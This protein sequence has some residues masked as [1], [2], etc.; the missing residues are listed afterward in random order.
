[1]L[2]YPG[3]GVAILPK[4]GRVKT[5]SAKFSQ[6]FR[7]GKILPAKSRSPCPVFRYL[8]DNCLSHRHPFYNPQENRRHDFPLFCRDNLPRLRGKTASPANENA[9]TGRQNARIVPES[10]TRFKKTARRAAVKRL[11][12]GKNRQAKGAENPAKNERKTS[13]F[14]A[15]C[16]GKREGL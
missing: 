8:V 9:G 4:T 2:I 1:M 16:I 13:K 11:P 3:G 7:G 14:P 10:D 6:S 5:K 15:L 12:D